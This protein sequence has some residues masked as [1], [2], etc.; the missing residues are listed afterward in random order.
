[1][2]TETNEHHD[3]RMNVLTEKYGP[4]FLMKCERYKSAE[5]QHLGNVRLLEWNNMARRFRIQDGKGW[6]GWV[7]VLDLDNFVL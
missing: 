7:D 2:I 5:H 4:D 3:Y 1:M 6:V